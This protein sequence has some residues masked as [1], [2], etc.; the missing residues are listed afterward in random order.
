MA[1]TSI[2]TVRDTL[3][4]DATL[5]AIATGGVYSMNGSGRA[6]VNETDT[7]TVYAT[8]ATS[9]I[10]IMRPC[11]VLSVTTEAVVGPTGIGRQEWLRVS[12][13]DPAVGYANT[14]A[15]LA[16]VHTLLHFQ[17]LS[18]TSG[19]WI[20]LE[21]IDTPYRVDV[22]ETIETGQGGRKGASMEASRYTM[23]TGWGA[24]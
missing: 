13:Y 23:V 21:H 1:T 17:H 20:H 22:D 3:A 16:R 18:L 24:Y 6:P 8:D 10:P 9:G 11:I 2:E 12:A 5:V 19:N 14:S 15:M 7:P 4:A